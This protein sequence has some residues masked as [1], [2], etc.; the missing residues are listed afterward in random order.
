MF[1]TMYNIKQTILLFFINYIV[2]LYYLIFL[3]KNFYTDN[4]NNN[5]RN[6]QHIKFVI[7]YNNKLLLF[8]QKS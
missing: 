8:I 3:K 7:I 4:K 2:T 6:I 5:L 1:S